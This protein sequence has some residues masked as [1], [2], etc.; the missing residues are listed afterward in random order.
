MVFFDSKRDT[1]IFKRS[2]TISLLMIDFKNAHE[3]FHNSGKEG[4][5]EEEERKKKKKK[6][7]TQMKR[8][9]FFEALPP[10]FLIPKMS[11]HQT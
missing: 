11:N 1:L 8:C 4:H 3:Q 6:P 5:G 2:I 7:S 10:T 9:F